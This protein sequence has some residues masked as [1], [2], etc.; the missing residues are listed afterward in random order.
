MT[1]SETEIRSVLTLLN[2]IE[3]KGIENAKRIVMIE[4]IL[5]QPEGEEEPGNGNNRKA[6]RGK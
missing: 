3:T 1:Y 5:Q 2:S 4:Q 6:Q